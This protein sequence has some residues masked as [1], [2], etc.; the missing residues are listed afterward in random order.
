MAKRIPQKLGRYEV[1]EE[2]GKGAMGVVYL[3][4]DPLIGRLLALKTFRLSM[5][6]DDSEAEQFR[7]RFMREAQSCGILSHPNIVIIHD[8]VEPTADTAGFIAME[9]VRGSNLKALMAK[10]RRFELSFILE[11]L[12][13]VASA[14]DYAHEKGVVHRDVKPANLLLTEEGNTVKIADF[15][16]A[17]LNT[18][19]LTQDGQ[20]LGTPNYMAPEQIRGNDVDH[21]ADLFALGVVLYEMLTRHKPFQGDNLTVVTHRIVYDRFEDPGQYIG[22][23][24]A[25]L[26]GVLDRAMAKD[27]AARYP[28]ATAMVEELRE[29]LNPPAG[30]PQPAP[31]PTLNQTQSVL[32]STLAA[33]SAGLGLERPLESSGTGT[34]AG[35]G[36]LSA[37]G[38]TGSS[39]LDSSSTGTLTDIS[40]VL[41]EELLG[42]QLLGDEGRAD[43][44]EAS[45]TGT[46]PGVASVPTAGAV[47]PP[48]PP[49]ASQPPGASQSPSAAPPSPPR[50][51][52]TPPSPPRP[53]PE[54][55]LLPD[56][57]ALDPPQPPQLPPAAAAASKGAPAGRAAKPGKPAAKSGGSGSRRGLAIAAAAALTL[58]LAAVAAFLLFRGGGEESGAVKEQQQW[59]GNVALLMMQGDRLVSDDPRSAAATFDEVRQLASERQLRLA[60]ERDRLLAEGDSKGAALQAQHLEVVEQTL[61]ESTERLRD[62]RWRRETKRMEAV[63]S[64]QLDRQRFLAEEALEAGDLPA[65]LTAAAAAL[66][67]DP[68]DERAQVLLARAEERYA[69]GRRTVTNRPPPPPPRVVEPEPEPEPVQVA[70]TLPPPPPEP[71]TATLSVVFKSEL[72]RGVLMIYRGEEQLLRESFRFEGGRSLFRRNASVEGRKD[73]TFT[74]PKGSSD[75]KVYVSGA[76]GRETDVSD[77]SANFPGGSTRVLEIDV[78][79]DGDVLTQMQ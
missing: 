20:L 15:G 28:N 54:A 50:T 2:L 43:A 45:S 41:G 49:S 68:S 25:P 51:G 4:K 57:D 38:G 36:S 48:P 39:G 9:Y 7:V 70:E 1:L 74:V 64:R 69:A 75:F 47:P 66:S 46:L 19:N 11:V 65:A 59:T 61:Q 34:S 12:E 35:T 27:P 73:Y 42:D 18:S 78:N 30:S 33:P 44:R 32:N 17:L 31:D 8:V 79:E 62:A 71:A 40:A 58:V 16:I 23:V 56:L 24:P 52:S 77:F 63:R 6:L 3:A 21:R 5:A 37:T 72:A 76:R 29:L 55:S 22:D 60:E 26:L 14:L 53:E 10:T 13:Q 67:F